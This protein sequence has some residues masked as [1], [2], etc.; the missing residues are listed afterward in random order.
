MLL[1][2]VGGLFDGDPR[3]P[4][5]KI[6]DTVERLDRSIYDLVCDKSGGRSKGGMASKLEAARLGTTAGENVIIASG[7][8]ADVLPKILA[9]EIVGTLF[10]AQG[11]SLAARKRWI[12]FTVKP[13][14]VLRLD[15][16]ARRPS[17]KRAA[18]CWP[19][20]W[21]NSTAISPRATWWPSAVPTAPKSPAA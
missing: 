8:D 5:V 2:D 21:W 1:S 12:G 18:A 17:S 10:L 13:R 3:D 19:P 7:R 6:I 4:G 20:G 16:G 15:E 9:G 11:Q 14:G